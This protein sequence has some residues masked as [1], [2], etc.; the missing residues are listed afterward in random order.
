MVIPANTDS[1]AGNVSIESTF[2]NTKFFLVGRPHKA[3]TLFSKPIHAKQ[4]R[5]GP[6]SAEPSPEAAM[7]FAPFGCTHPLPTLSAEAEPISK[8]TLLE[9]T[10]Q[11]PKPPTSIG[12]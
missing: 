10:S 11:V 8:R 4:E 3:R 1:L 12:G 9:V 5:S 2:K 7:L 6:P